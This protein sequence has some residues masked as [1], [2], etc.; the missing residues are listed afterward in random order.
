MPR[1][2]YILK[3]GTD[4]PGVTTI[5]GSIGWGKNALIGWSNKIGLQGIEQKTELKRMADIGSCAHDQFEAALTRKFVTGR[6]WPPEIEEAARPPVQAFDQ[7][8]RG[9]NL[10][11]VA[12][13]FPL[14][15]E[16]FRV[17]GTPDGIVRFDR[18]PQILI[19][20]KT[21]SALYG[22][23]I[24]QVAAYVAMIK[25]Q[26]DKTIT[27]ALVLRFGK[28]GAAEEL[29]VTGQ[30]LEDGLELFQ[31]ALQLYRLESKFKT[32]LRAAKQ[33]DNDLIPILTLPTVA[34]AVPA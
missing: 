27:S 1:T 13:E 24:A 21:S 16:V 10:Q 11:L 2:R 30:M 7:W 12:S 5:L 34:K 31:I 15:S 33:I 3:D 32:H 6:A 28:D 19:D 22:T 17:G 18:G 8:R 26:Y 25:H 4:A 14:V 29:E 9:K 20:W 23:Y